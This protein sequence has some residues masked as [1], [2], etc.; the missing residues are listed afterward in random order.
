MTTSPVLFFLPDMLKYSFYIIISVSMLT[1]VYAQKKTPAD[2][3]LL[4]LIDKRLNDAAA[5]YR[6]FT[7]QTND[8]LFPK[9]VKKNGDLENSKSWWWCSGFYPGTLIYLNEYQADDT[10]SRAAA[11]Y[12]KLLEKEQYNK[13]THDLGFMMYCSFG[14]VQRLSPTKKYQ[15]ILVQSAKS[16]AT[17]YSPVTGSIRSWNSKD[18]TD[19]LVIIDNMMNLELLFYATRVTGDSSFYK[20]ALNHADKT[21]QN[22][23][24]EDYSSYHVVNYNAQTGA[25]K[26]RRTQQGASNASAWARGQAWGLY[27]YTVMYRETRQQKYLDMANRIANF[28][29]SHPNI[30]DDKVAYW[31]FNA[32]DI[33]HALRDASAAAIMAS[34]LTEL[35]TYNSR[36]LYKKY[37]KAAETMITSLSEA[38][39]QN[40]YKENRGFILKHSVGSLPHN[41]EVDVPLTYADYYYVEAMLRYRQLASGK[42]TVN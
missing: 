21:I 10:L 24:R 15:D 25:V 23:F 39:Y 37:I 22:H 30:P 12:L 6:Y 18:S 32:P 16:L 26:L 11:H 3:A 17:R 1:S 2:K 33:P 4:A 36:T 28:V 35:A 19:F 14:N 38:P 8:T 13:G 31:D 34:A 29:L 20:I 27:G 42:K 40:S 41:S 7:T 5:Q 9:T